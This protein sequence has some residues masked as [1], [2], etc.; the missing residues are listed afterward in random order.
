M[1]QTLF[2]TVPQELSLLDKL[3][4]GIAKTRAG[5]IDRLDDV[6]GGKREIDA[7]LLEEL[8]YT[9]LTAD[10]GVRTTTEILTACASVSTAS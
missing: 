2:G 8:E 5:F 10:I 4:S 9:L 1:I 3:K 6:I 7:D